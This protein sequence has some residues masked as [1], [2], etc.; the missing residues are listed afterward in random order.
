MKK[1]TFLV[2][3]MAV[4]WTGVV[5]AT[6]VQ[7]YVFQDDMSTNPCTSGN[8]NYAGNNNWGFDNVM[9]S[10]YSATPGT[11]NWGYN[12]TDKSYQ[13]RWVPGTSGLTSSSTRTLSTAVQK[14]S[15]DNKITIQ[16]IVKY[17]FTG[18]GTNPGCLYF[19][20]ENG[21]VITGIAFY[22]VSKTTSATNFQVGL[23]SSYNGGA[24]DS[25][26]G[27]FGLPASTST[28]PS[29]VATSWNGV[30]SS[31]T[32]PITVRVTL[33]LDFSAA[34]LNYTIENGTFNTGTRAFTVSGSPVTVT[35]QAFI[36]AAAANFKKFNQTFVRN[37]GASPA[38]PP[39]GFDMYYMGVSTLQTISSTANVSVNYYDADNTSSLI[40]TV[41]IANQAVGNTYTASGTDKASFTQS[42]YYYTY[43]SMQSDNQTIAGDGSTHVDVLMKKYPVYNGTYTWTGVT[44]GNWNELTGN[45][46]DGTNTLGYQPGYGV[47]FA[48]GPSNKTITL[49][50]SVNLGSGDLT[51]S[52]DGYT[53][54]G[55]GAVAGTGKLAINLAGTQTATLNLTNNMTGVTSI[56]GGNVIVK[57]SGVLGVTPNISGGAI[58]TS[59]VTSWSCPALN[60]TGGTDS[61]SIG[62][63]QDNVLSGLSI[64]AGAKLKISSGY[65]YASSDHRGISFAASGTLSSGSELELNGTGTD[66][67][68]GMT[69]ASTSYLAN[70]KLTLKGGAMFYINATQGAPTI[71]NIGSLASADATTKLGWGKGTATNDITYSVGASNEST[72]Y[73]GSLTN[74][75]GYNSGGTSYTGNNTNLEKVGTGTLTLSGTITHNGVVTIS[76]G[77]LNVTGSLGSGA[78][79][80]VASTGTLDGTGTISGT[81]IINGTIKGSLKFSRDVTVAAG[82]TIDAAANIGLTTNGGSSGTL[83]LQDGTTIPTLTITSTSAPAVGTTIQV[84]N[85]T[86]PS[87]IIYTN[88]PVVPSGYSFSTATG[89]L[90]Y[91]GSTISSSTNISTAGLQ[92]N[93]TITVANG[94]LL[95]INQASAIN[96]ITVNPTAQLTLNSGINLTGAVAL[97]SST[98]GTAT[99]VDADATGKTVT[100]TVEQCL[101][102]GRNWYVGVPV[103]NAATVPYTALT[104]AGASSVSYWDEANGAWVSGYTGTLYRGVGYIAVSS[105]G[106]ATNNISF[107]GTL[108]T[109]NIPVTVTRTPGKTKEGFNLIA[110]PYPSYLN[111]CALITASAKMEPTIWYR[112][113]GTSYT[114]ETV[115]TASGEGTNNVTGYIPPMQAFWVRVKPNATDAAQPNSETLTFTNAMRYH[116]NPSGVTTTLLKT[117][118]AAD[119]VQRIRL[120]VSNGVNSDETLLYTNSLASNQ[121]DN[122]DSNKL[123]NDNNAIPEIFTTVDGENLVINGFNQ[124]PLNQEI[125]LGFKTGQSNSFTLTAIQISNL[126]DALVVLKD[127]VLNTETELTEGTGYN[128]SSDAVTTTNRFSLVLKSQGA[129]TNLGSQQQNSEFLIYRNSKNQLVFSGVKAGECVTL[130]NSLGQ[131][132]YT[133]KLT[134]DTIQ[135]PSN[136]LSGTYLIVV[137]NITKKFIV[138]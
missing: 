129:V 74:T 34:T 77:T 80:T 57:K 1:I 44:D 72:T 58:I 17:Y 118:A 108:N 96:I 40:K 69:S 133:Q 48:S 19:A 11:T 65:N 9:S 35:G 95:T 137:N 124:L 78:S 87:S 91:V 102:T 56:S 126:T 33:V 97:Q 50:S 113:K 10:S 30:S 12:S 2:M 120:Q 45:F 112:T 123:T 83:N 67:R 116:A 105:A 93:A 51:V 47:A 88:T 25:G 31:S 54:Q 53:L 131:K 94:N 55:S 59:N 37:A 73:A 23:C 71:I 63:Y 121:Y 29:V 84:V 132:V 21:N 104:T 14:S 138:E 43:S 82:A 13:F 36:N 3:V 75:G 79:V 99:F 16:T 92:N 85:A 32:L 41:A 52:G 119:A 68:M 107:S 76:N 4:V 26:T 117:R 22:S 24:Y 60:I 15:V 20:D 136:L 86:T 18:R 100:G 128:F 130:F 109:G 103:T 115:N 127:K 70:T 38:T 81:T 8:T 7:T 6:D 39:Y 90:T 61:L 5:R 135:L 98:S 28:F 49:N 66:N 134:A 106:S 27:L 62:T 122:Y 64:S 114:F 89:I 46:T 110:N 125:A 111:P 101:P 42:S